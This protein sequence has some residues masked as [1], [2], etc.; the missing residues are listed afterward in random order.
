[1]TRITEIFEKNFDLIRE[2]F[3]RCLKHTDLG[4]YYLT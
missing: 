4:K 1:M 3:V 2:Y